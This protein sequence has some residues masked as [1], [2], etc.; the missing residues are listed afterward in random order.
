MLAALVEHRHIVDDDT[1]EQ[2]HGDSP[3]RHCRSELLRHRRRH[4]TPQRRL[5]DGDMHKGND[6]EVK[7]YRH[8]YDDIDDASECLQAEFIK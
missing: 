6:G 7:T 3:H 2:P 8:P 4:G 1:V 5:Y